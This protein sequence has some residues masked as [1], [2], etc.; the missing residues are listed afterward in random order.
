M[1]ILKD[2]FKNKM[3]GAPLKSVNKTQPSDG[4]ERVVAEEV[5]SSVDDVKNIINESLGF[6]P[7]VGDDVI[8]MHPSH[9]HNG[10]ESPARGKVVHDHGNGK[11]NI[12][13]HMAGKAHEPVTVH[14]GKIFK[15]KDYDSHEKALIRNPI[16]YDGYFEGTEPS[17]LLQSTDDPKLHSAEHSDPYFLGYGHYH[18][19]LYDIPHPK[20]PH[21]VNSNAY[22]NWHSEYQHGFR[23]RTNERSEEVK[24][25]GE[26]LNE[27]TST[28]MSD[29]ATELVN[30]GNNESDL[31]HNSKLPI[32]KN[33]LKKKAKGVYDSHLA[34]KLWG[35][36]A[37][38][39]AQSYHKQ[40]GTE[41]QP[42]H[43]L[44][45][46]EDRMQAAAHWE[47]HTEL[48]ESTL[49]EYKIGDS[50]NV[51]KE[52]GYTLGANSFPLHGK[53]AKIVGKSF[54][55]RHI[56]QVDTPNGSQIFHLRSN[57]MRKLYNPDSVKTN[58]AVGDGKRTDKPAN[59]YQ[60]QYS[61]SA[62]DKAIASSN[63]GGKNIGG[64]EAKMIHALLRGRQVDPEPQGWNERDRKKPVIEMA[65]FKIK[66]RAQTYNPDRET[67]T[68]DDHNFEVKAVSRKHALNKGVDHIV[69]KFPH[70]KEHEV[71]IVKEEVELIADGKQSNKFKR[72][73][74]GTM[75]GRTATGKP[76]HFI[77]TKPEIEIKKTAN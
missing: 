29:A 51:Y 50:V 34:T 57:E 75:R 4:D 35:Y 59:V 76:A 46:K 36:H 24:I 66:G 26:S 47:K 27:L 23:D 5:V 74:L 56:V 37:D 28:P 52:R 70:H 22:H 39:A 13:P 71:S 1:S 53:K 2:R 16:S 43:K 31:Y 64:R 9:F 15:S 10:R 44:F 20:N 69:K 68:V 54:N 42:W 62:V 8:Y 55:G 25:D 65:T 7:L 32:M 41:D 63:R 72:K 73:Y 14:H 77:D 61:Q 19:Q 30:H 38:R 60:H 18:R 49:N 11:F 6:K 21:P 17:K 33:L 58:E 3:R 67:W 45:S 12:V 40:Y 48:H